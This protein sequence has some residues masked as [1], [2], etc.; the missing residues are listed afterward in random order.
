MDGKRKCWLL[1]VF[2]AVSS[3]TPLPTQDAGVTEAG[4]S[5]DVPPTICGERTDADGDTI[6][7][8]TEGSGDSDG[9]G[10]ADRRDLDSDADGISDAAE[11]GDED[12]TTP[13]VDT[14]E[15][16][17]PD[18]LD[19]DSDNDGASDAEEAQAGS[20]RLTAD[21][22]GDGFGDLEEI[23]YSD[24][25]CEDEPAT[26][27]CVTTPEC[28]P[29]E[30]HIVVLAEGQNASVDLTFSTAIPSADVFFLVDTT[31]SMDATLE[32][33]KNVLDGG[34]DGG[35]LIA[36]I[37]AHIPDVRF[38][39]GQHDDFP[40]GP[41]GSGADETFLLARA[42]TP[43]ASAELL[44]EAL[45]AM[46]LHSGGDGPE[47]HV[48]ALHQLISG[49]GGSWQ[50]T[51]GADPGSYEARAS[52]GDC[53]SGYGAACFREGVMPIV[54]HFTNACAHNGPPGESVECTP[55]MNIDPSVGT[56]NS[57]VSELNERGTKYLGVNVT[58]TACEADAPPS[59]TSPCFFLQQTAT[60]TGTVSPEGQ[61][62]TLD[63]ANDSGLPEFR[64]AL[65]AAVELVATR[66]PLEVRLVAVGEAASF[67]SAL[68]P[69]CA[70]DAPSTPCWTPPPGV[71]LADA[72]EAVDDSSF[73]GVLPGTAVLFRVDFANESVALGSRSQ[74]SQG[75]LEARGGPL[76]LDGQ[77][78]IVAIPAASEIYAN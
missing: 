3:C 30:V 67:V 73:Q 78:L 42:M 45:A 34:L 54:L 53:L 55:Y 62:L 8:D 38:G 6:A 71:A 65:A 33:V 40:L 27:E 72:V 13:P 75:E 20:M 61:P 24:F 46:E 16:G 74:S 23:A 29:D 47:A 43:P 76:F 60:A 22:D 39:G 56:W 35:D 41:Y 17:L 11:A 77:E 59:T 18:Y 28:S 15:D 21:S 10:T 36:Q 57:M 19:N 44:V 26:C 4:V 2:L 1:G 66:V 64:T 37:Q 63:V 14:D 70:G 9:D 51:A 49:D 5:V 32:N 25:Y 58:R 31:A 69:A 52:A 12:C 7:D 48:Q 68:R 50:Y